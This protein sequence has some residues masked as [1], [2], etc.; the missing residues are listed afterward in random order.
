MQHTV[1]LSRSQIETIIQ[2]T[3][4]DIL[5]RVSLEFDLNR[6]EVDKFIKDYK[7]NMII[8][9]AQ[10]HYNRYSTPKSELN[11]RAD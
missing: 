7:E 10:I 1:K 2:Y 5:E 9:S 3:F 8:S 6:P 11:K 4:E